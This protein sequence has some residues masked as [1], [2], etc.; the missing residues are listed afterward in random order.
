M[1][2]FQIQILYLKTKF[3]LKAGVDQEFAVE[4]FRTSTATVYQFASHPQPPSLFTAPPSFSRL[5][6]VQDRTCLTATPQPLEETR[7]YHQ[8]I[9]TRP[10]TT[11]LILGFGLA[12]YSVAIG[13]PN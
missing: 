1:K 6:T 12:E 10:D 3:V 8:L 2:R 9:P 13:L 5:G 4:R 7:P 11:R